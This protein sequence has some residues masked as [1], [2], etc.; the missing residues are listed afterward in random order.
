MVY[1]IAQN[2]KPLMPTEHYGKVRWLL[3][4]KRAKVARRSPFTIQLLYGTGS[5]RVQPVAL[6]VDAGYQTAGVCNSL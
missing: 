4:R 5:E 1:V 2:G 6:G 3:K